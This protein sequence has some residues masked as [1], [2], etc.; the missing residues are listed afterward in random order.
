MSNKKKEPWRIIVF[1][2]SVSYIVFV[3]IKKDILT[4]YSTMP[5]EQVAPLIATTVAVS[6]LKVGAIAGTI[7]LMKWI[8]EKIGN[9]HK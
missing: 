2:I 9:R 8:V 4:I 5:K 7:L 6:L 1:I 3:W